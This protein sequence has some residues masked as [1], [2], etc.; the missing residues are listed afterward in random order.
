MSSLVSG[1]SVSK[2]RF[3][4]GQTYSAAEACGNWTSSP[5]APTMS[6]ARMDELFKDRT[7]RLLKPR[8]VNIVL[9]LPSPSSAARE[10][11]FV[12]TPDMPTAGSAWRLMKVHIK[13]R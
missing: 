2:E 3:A 5:I 8:L 1:P 12:Y 13:V 7:T 11:A 9:S 4:R 10:F 6:P